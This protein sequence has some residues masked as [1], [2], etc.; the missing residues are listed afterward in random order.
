M[1]HS[2]SGTNITLTRGDSLFLDIGI[3]IEVEEDVFEPFTPEEGAN[4]RFALK[5]AFD[6]SYPVLIRKD[7]P[8]DTMI[9]ELEPED[10]KPLVMKKTYV[11]DVQYT[12][13]DGHVDTIIKGKFKIG[14]EVD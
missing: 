6:D 9:L 5:E 8:L 14:E 2:I 13:P 12:D 10:T 4:L 3:E 7:I 11:Y 1:S